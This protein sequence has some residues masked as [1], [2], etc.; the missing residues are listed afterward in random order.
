MTVNL[1]VGGSPSKFFHLKEFCNALSKFEVTSKLVHDS[2]IVD[3]FPSR[4]IQ[5]WC[6][7]RKKFNNLI[8]EFKPD[9]ILIDRQRHFGLAVDK[10]NIPLFVH[11]RGDYWKEM[12]MA[13]DT[14]YKSIPKRIAIKKWEEIGNRC[15]A[16]S[17]VI[18][19]ICKYLENI[20]KEHYPN[21]PTEVL[22]QGI[23]PQNWYPQKG[24]N[25]KHPCVGLLQDARIWEKTKEMLTLT[26]V[27][28]TMPDV[29]FYWAGDGPYRDHVLPILEKYQNFKWLGTLQYPDE[30]R[31]FLT[32]I[33]VYA[34]I[35][36]IDMSPLTL[37]EAQL[38]Q[39]P[40]VATSV[41]GIPELMQ[42]NETGF[43][44][45]K[46]N[47]D[48][49]IEKISTLVNNDDKRKQMGILGRSFIE[50]N[51]NWEIIAK[52]F[53]DILNSYLDKK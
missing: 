1:L 32:E 35:S 2:E 13:K 45:E 30:V 19:P 6:Q 18:L 8:K 36:G 22:Y 51:F 37:Q 33:D 17:K 38:M 11:L 12:K 3:G 15:F 49:I 9:I 50:K 44:V 20:V 10:T 43:L 28:E 5:N 52:R 53:S 21:K 26:K 25:L 40:V 46:Q 4:K 7:T 39:K 29:T 23:T 48:E 31:K 24:M 34:L 42:N 27:I 41:G 14:L 16:A 47:S